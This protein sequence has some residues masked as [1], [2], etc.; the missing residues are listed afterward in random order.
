MP[1]IVHC[2][3]GADALRL[4]QEGF[5]AHSHHML[6]LIERLRFAAPLASADGAEVVG[7]ERLAGSLLVFADD[8]V[9]A[10]RKAVAQ[11]PYMQSGAWRQ[12]DL[13][14]TQTLFGAWGPD[15]AGQRNLFA[16]LTDTFDPVPAGAR[17]YAVFCRGPGAEAAEPP[18]Q[19]EHA[20]YIGRLFDR[21]RLGVGL[22]HLESLGLSPAT[23]PWRGLYLHKALTLEDAER[24]GRDDPFSRQGLWQTSAFASPAAIGAW[25]DA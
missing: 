13:Y 9:A 1:I 23:P 4:R 6:G 5:E 14:R 15:A 19:L 2:Q 18:L 8:D 25:V 24:L 17:L 3:D 7:D 12:A 21:M 10:A 16:G 22:D 11:D 20:R